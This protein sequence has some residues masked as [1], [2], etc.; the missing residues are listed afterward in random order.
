[1]AVVEEVGEAGRDDNGV[2]VSSSVRRER[3]ERET[4]GWGL[5]AS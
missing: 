4:L 3:R 1:M 2:A 5:G